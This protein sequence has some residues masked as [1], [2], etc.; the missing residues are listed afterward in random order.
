MC[1][2]A[3]RKHKDTRVSPFHSLEVALELLFRPRVFQAG[4]VLL[5]R[6]ILEVWIYIAPVET[7]FSVRRITEVIDLV[8]GFAEFGYN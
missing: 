3:A 2:S 6:P 1:R 7:A 5:D 8:S 4:S